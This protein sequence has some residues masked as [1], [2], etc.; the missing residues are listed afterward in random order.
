[1]L[2]LFPEI[3]SFATHRL[4][5]SGGHELY[6]EQAGNPQGIPVLVVHGGPGS[7]CDEQD[8]RFFDAERYHIILFDQRGSGRSTPLAALHENTTP[9]LLADVEQ[10]RLLLGVDRWLLFGGS[11]GATLS[12][13]YAQMH[14]QRVLGLIVRGTF[15]CRRE[16]FLW[17]YQSG[18]SRVFPDY[19]KDFIAIIPPEEQGDLLAAYY[20]RL[21]SDNE[22]VQIQA[23]KAWACWDARC[24]TLNPNPALVDCVSHPH[25][26]ISLARIA[27]HYFMHD[28][29]M[30]PNQ[31]IA[32]ADRL[33][34]IP[35]II[36]H[37]RYDMQCPLD[38][39]FALHEAW[40]DASLVILRDA[41][42][43]ATEPPTIDALI[44]ATEAMSERFGPAFSLF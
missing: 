43:A 40:P 2:T 41:G 28:I 23:A 9:D 39:A 5:V 21:T 20:R 38:N 34:G 7:G 29:F 11:W 37:G 36:V 10:V 22:L 27:C 19:W 4:Q 35:G 25:K 42:H 18:A 17:F 8:R 13:L 6:I 33:K 30:G 44:R 26:A 1:M 32:N 15:L 3:K 14:P 12:L 24:A 16:D 31:V